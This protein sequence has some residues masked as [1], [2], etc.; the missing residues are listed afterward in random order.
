[1]NRLLILLTIFTSIVNFSFAQK[2][3]IEERSAKKVPEWLYTQPSDYVVVEVQAGNISEAR[4]K[5]VE[6]IARRIITAVATNVAYDNTSSA[7]TVSVNGKLSETETFAFDTKM[8]SARLPF[9]K[10]ISLTEAKDTYWEK[11]RENDTNRIFYNYSVLY[12]LSKSELEDMRKEFNKID[13]EKSKTLEDL[14]MQLNS[15]TGS[16]QIEQAVTKLDELKEYFFDNVRR[17]ET[18]GLIANYKKLYKGLTV[19]STKPLNGSFKVTVLLNGRP[20]EVTGVPTLKSNCAYK[21]AA[22]PLPD[23][24]GYEITYDDTDCLDD[25]ENWI[26]INLRMRDTRLTHRI[27]L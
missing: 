3:K 19:Q 21:L 25:E 7:K 18:E 10:G 27:F 22:R 9:I 16:L 8:A 20:F 14:K 24:T 13:D 12:P 1:M 15:V 11:R 2:S 23:G 17:N 26:D 4:D 6:E 5:A